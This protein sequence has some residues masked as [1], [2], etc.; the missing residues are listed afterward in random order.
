MNTISPVSSTEPTGNFTEQAE[1]YARSRPGYP[2]KLIDQLIAAASVQ[3]GDAIA[4]IG[5]GTGLFTKSLTDRGFVITAIEPTKAMRDR[6]MMWP[7][8]QWQNGTFEST[9]LADQSQRWV[10]AAQAFH[11]ADP[12]RALPEIRRI[13]K[14]GC[15]FTVLWNN[16]QNDQH[17]IT[18]W[19][20][21]AID[22]CVP[23]FSHAYRDTDWTAALQSTG[24][25]SHVISHEVEHEVSMNNER[26]LDLWRSHHRLNTIA[27]PKR[28]AA[29]MEEL[30]VHLQ[31]QRGDQIDVPYLCKA[32]TAR[33]IE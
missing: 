29:F 10:V 6:A 1:V 3:H 18:Q 33:R 8:V 22:R 23:E 20:R 14:P 16:R 28:M 12:P 7:N 13:L 21:A 25:F 31:E 24:D 5:A 26:Y 15:C 32:W 19:T 4:E 11:W 27:G 30:Q 2:C 9:G 17:P